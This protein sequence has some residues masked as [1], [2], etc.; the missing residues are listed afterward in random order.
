MTAAQKAAYRS[1]QYEFVCAKKCV[2]GKKAEKVSY[3]ALTDAVEDPRAV[4][5]KLGHTAVADGAVLGSQRLAD[6]TG[7]TKHI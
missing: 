5:V 6:H 1:L 7:A 2:Q 4:V 3:V